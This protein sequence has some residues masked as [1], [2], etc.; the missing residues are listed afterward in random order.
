MRK[1]GKGRWKAEVARAELSRWENSGLSL[2]EFSQRR[3]YPAHRLYWWRRRF[4]EASTANTGDTA[5]HIGDETRSGWV[6]ATITGLGVEPAVVVQL[7]GGIR[8]EVASPERVSPIW[9]ASAAT[10]LSRNG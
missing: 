8:I 6:A 1:M 9:L 7:N 2:R 5:D 10:E 3:G 4:S